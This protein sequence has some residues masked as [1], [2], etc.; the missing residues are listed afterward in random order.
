MKKTTALLLGIVL[1]SVG[2][3]LAQ[4]NFEPLFN[5]KDLKG[6]VQYNGQAKYTVEQGELVGRTV[7]GQPNSFL[8]TEKKYGDFILELDLKV[9]VRMN[10]G[11]QFRSEINDGNDQCEVTDT[12]TP[13]RVHGYQ[14]EIDPSSRAWSGG[15]YDEARRGW[16]YPLE[17]NTA[18]KTAFKNN[19]WN[20]YKIEAIGTS[21]RTWVNGVPCA[22]IIDNMTPS[23]FI[24]LQVHEIGDSKDAGQEV[25]WKNI[26]IQTKNLKPTAPDNLFVVNLI[27]NTISAD[28]KRNGV[29]LLW[30]GETTKGWRGAYK[31]YF[32][33]NV[34][35]IKE[36]VLHVKGTNGAEASN[37]G[38]I[39]TV[40]EFHAFDL[41][42]EFQLSD[43]ANS[44][45]KYFVTETE[46]NKG[47]AI[48]LEYQILDDDKHPDAF[49]GSIGNRT[50][51]S[52]YDLIPALRIG[53]G[54]REKIPI[55]QWNRGRI[56][57]FPD[58][59]IEHWVNGWKV[60]E[61]QRGTQYFYAL[62]AKSKYVNWKNFGMAEKGH[63]LLQEH[64]THVA[65]RSIK[66]KEL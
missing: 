10:S 1:T 22:H 31:N 48:G 28:E 20:H 45:I 15:V 61:Y 54:R 27:P 2:H 17:Y 30:D 4:N 62:V 44:G 58:G 56:I 29:R 9:D 16:L 6:W 59:K 41:Q 49:Q 18:A 63:I 42:F 66:I 21:I 43:T 38:D 51:A 57:V 40:D 23:G 11:I 32:P 13:N 12:H 52:L 19:V 14:M 33:E 55:G 8:S 46:N 35:Y 60:V 64:G 39:V 34:W 37:G 53:E 65:F 7:P 5:G 25:R 26:K 24:S 36:G 47:S 3:L 50:N